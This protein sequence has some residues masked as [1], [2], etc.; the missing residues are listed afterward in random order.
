VVVA[1]TLAMTSASASADITASAPDTAEV[2]DVAVMSYATD[3]SVTHAEAQRRLD[4]IQPLQSILEEIRE[5]ENARLAGW[6]IDH[7]VTFTG[8]VWLTGNQPPSSAAK[9]IADAHTDIQIR[10]GAVHSLSELSAAQSGL[11]QKVG[12]VGHTGV[13]GS[14]ATMKR[15]V[16]FTSIDM[17]ANALTIG[18]DP[19]LADPVLGEKR[20]FG[21]AGVTNEAL[22][23][24]I[25]KITR[26]LQ[27]HINVKYLVEDG[28]D[29]GSDA[30]F[31]GGESIMPGCTA[32]FAAR[33]TNHG[34]Y[35]ILTAGHCGNKTQG[36]SAT[37]SMH[38]IT[39]PYINGW[40][41]VSADAQFHRI[42]SGSLHALRDDYRCISIPRRAQYCDVTGTIGRNS[43]IDDYICH[44][45]DKSG[46]S[47][48]RITSL[49]HQPDHSEACFSSRGTEID[50]ARTFI[51]V[52]GDYL[53]ACNGDSG[54]PWYRNGEAYGLH[55]GS[56]GGLNCSRNGVRAFFSPIHQVESF[57]GVQVLTAG[58]VTIQ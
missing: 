57:L 23:T 54:G 27:D 32:G 7:E 11:F 56:N 22:Q 13:S 4:R 43:M 20:S 31:G 16:T 45:G 34:T 26:Q 21:P 58:T 28:R 10:T 49:A 3:Y 17:R 18:I 37:F 38:D 2:V 40:A 53:R 1:A 15:I 8:W 39:L 44:T 41:S 14:T 36:E 35:G 42:P 48:G 25:T 30:V 47:C 52:E 46:I 9:T 33:L 12:P 5:L 24:E 55:M 19:E 50:C 29:L 6:G 51:L